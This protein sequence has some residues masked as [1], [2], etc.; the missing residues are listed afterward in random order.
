MFA[1]GIGRAVQSMQLL[2]IASTEEY[3]IHGST[4]FDMVDI[5]WK[6]V[7]KICPFGKGNA[8]CELAYTNC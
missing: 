5:V 1:V 7:G 4:F 2:E 6:I 8:C 3:V